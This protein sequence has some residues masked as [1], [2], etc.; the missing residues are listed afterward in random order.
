MFCYERDSSYA[1]CRF[2]TIIKNF[3]SRNKHLT[4]K[5]LKDG[6][7]YQIFHKVNSIADTQSYLLNVNAGLKSFLEQGVSKP[8]FS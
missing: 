8:V 7:R 5:L 4:A 2:L 3:T 6:Y 1:C